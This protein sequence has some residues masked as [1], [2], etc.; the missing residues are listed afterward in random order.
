MMETLLERACGLD[1]HKETVTACID[2]R[3]IKKEIRTFNTMTKDLLRLKEWI[4]DKDITH[5]AM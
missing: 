2:G 1:V 4:K 3:G 5:V